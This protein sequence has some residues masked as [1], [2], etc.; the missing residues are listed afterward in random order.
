[1]KLKERLA[2]AGLGFSLAVVVL[3]LLDMN[4]VIP[5]TE[6]GKSQHG[7]VKMGGRER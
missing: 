6:Q 1:M 3:V 2:M 4:M 7:R 5:H